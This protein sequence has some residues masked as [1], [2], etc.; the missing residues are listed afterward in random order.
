MNKITETLKLAE[1]VEASAEEYMV[2]DGMVMVIPLDLY[3]DLMGALAAIR[4]SRADQDHIADADKVIAE[5][6]NTRSTSEYS[7]PVKQEPVCSV[8]CKTHDKNNPVGL[9]YPPA[10]ALDS[11]EQAASYDNPN[12]V[13]LYAAPVDV[14]AIRAEA[15]EEA[16]KVCRTAQAKGLQSIREA[17]EA[18]IRGLK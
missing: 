11:W 1:L 4:K 12:A 5:P 18:A 13:P 7:E 8:C 9:F 15:L 6:A 14:K 3:N 10:N 2:E 17:I 16:A